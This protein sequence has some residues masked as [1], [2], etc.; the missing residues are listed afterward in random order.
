MSTSESGP[1]GASRIVSDATES[2]SRSFRFFFGIETRPERP[3]GLE[4]RYRIAYRDSSNRLLDG[5]DRSASFCSPAD[6]PLES[7]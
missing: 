7:Q 1:V 2:R 5:N 4:G 3:R 6:H